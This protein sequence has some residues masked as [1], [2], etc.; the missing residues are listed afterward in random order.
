[1]MKLPIALPPCSGFILMLLL[2]LNLAQPVYADAQPRSGSETLLEFEDAQTKDR[3]YSLLEQLRC[4]VCQNQSL[5][6]SDAG[7]AQDLRRKVHEMLQEG[8]GDR[9]IIDFMVARYGDFVLY[10]PPLK[11]STVLL[12]F[13][14][15]ILAGL[16][17]LG[18]VIYLLRRNEQKA[19]SLLSEERRRRAAELLNK[20]KT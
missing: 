5:A 20:S 17:I 3:Y 7:L 13:G 2:A 19:E 18:L 15:F 8:A 1:M 4:L 10:N 11:T 9:E 6:D 16:G 12:W 14:P